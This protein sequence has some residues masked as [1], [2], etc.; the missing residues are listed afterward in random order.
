LPEF[1]HCLPHHDKS[2]RVPA[3]VNV[4]HEVAIVERRRRLGG[5]IDVPWITDYV[6][7]SGVV[8][9]KQ[10]PV[11]PAQLRHLAE[12]GLDARAGL[13][14]ADQFEV[15]SRDDGPEV[16]TNVGARGVRPETGG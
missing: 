14:P 15:V 13:R 3:V 4:R 1:G 7:G 10:E 8:P 2:R 12:R 5:A 9:L 11:V 16:Y 6:T